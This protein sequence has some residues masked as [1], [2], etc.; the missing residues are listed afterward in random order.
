[1]WLQIMQA[2]GQIAR[3]VAM[4]TQRQAFE[5]KAAGSVEQD[6]RK[7]GVCPLSGHGN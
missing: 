1:M 3:P 4:A 5:L 7:F 2:F 6:N